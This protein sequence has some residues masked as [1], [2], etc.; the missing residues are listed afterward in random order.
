MLTKLTRLATTFAAFTKAAKE[1]GA[2]CPLTRYE[3]IQLC[4][5]LGSVDRLLAEMH[6]TPV[7]SEHDDKYT[8]MTFTFKGV[9]F[10]YLKRVDK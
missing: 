8:Q 9:E 3:S 1:F 10:F 4:N 6:I 7:E 2:D 5:Y